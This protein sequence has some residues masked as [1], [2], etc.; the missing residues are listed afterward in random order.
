MNLSFIPFLTTT[1]IIECFMIFLFR[2]TNSPFSG[3]S[4]NKWYTNLTWTAVILDTLS[5]MIGFYLAKYIFEKCIYNKNISKYK[6]YTYYLIIVLI[7]QILHD[8]LFWYFIIRTSKKGN[9]IVMDEFIDYANDIGYK[10]I[11][12]DSFM[13]LI[14]VPILYLISNNSNELNIFITIVCYYLIGYIIHKKV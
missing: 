10:A 1:S 12:G 6:L 14:G 5:V 13:Y 4:I 9:S 8:I 3:K 2:Y 11:L 7:V